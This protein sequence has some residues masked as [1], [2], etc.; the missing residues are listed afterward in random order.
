MTGVA[1]ELTVAECNNSV[2]VTADDGARD[3]RMQ[4]G[5]TD[6]VT[7]EEGSVR[8]PCNSS[9]I[10]I[11]D[12]GARDQRIQS[13]AT[14]G[15]TGEEGNVVGDEGDERL[16]DGWEKQYF[17]RRAV[18]RGSVVRVRR[19]TKQQE[20]EW[21]LQWQQEARRRGLFSTTGIYDAVQWQQP[22]VRGQKVGAG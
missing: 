9:K 12:G 6:G 18:G 22:L 5:A 15:A 21:Q 8:G 10:V 14:D 3:R 20:N 7:K 17:V 2:F 16:R 19:S 11:A 1:V 4:S 13:D